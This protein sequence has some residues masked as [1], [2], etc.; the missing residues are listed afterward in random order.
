V[1]G[2]RAALAAAPAPKVAVS[3]IVGGRALKG[4]ADQMLASLGHEVSAYGVARI[5]GDAIDGLVIDETDADLAA[6]IETDG[7]RVRVAQTIMQS[8]ADRV[9]LARVTLD[10]AAELAR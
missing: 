6:R 9:A 7:P 10:F 5:L 1:P 3:P 4:P 8:D 2:L